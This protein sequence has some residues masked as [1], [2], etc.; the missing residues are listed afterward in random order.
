MLEK[1]RKGTSPAS[2][3]H[4]KA[5][6]DPKDTD[7]PTG[8]STPGSGRDCLD[9]TAPAASHLDPARGALQ[10]P[11]DHRGRRS[12]RARRVLL[13]DH[14]NRIARLRP[15]PPRSAGSVAARDARGTRD[16]PMSNPPEGHARS[17]R[18]RHPTTNHGPAA[19]RIRAYQSDPRRAQQPGSRPTQPT[20][21]PFPT[22][23]NSEKST[24]T[25]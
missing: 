2:L 1:D 6:C 7:R 16:L 18:Q 15:R 21:H 22:S 3:S 13:G 5:T 14:P 20:T 9:R 4:P 10:A 25:P 17:H 8:R 24:R 11:H 12:T 19:T 23:A